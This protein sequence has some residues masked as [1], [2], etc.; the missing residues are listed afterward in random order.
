MGGERAAAEAS[1]RLAARGPDGEEYLVAW[2]LPPFFHEIPVD[3]DDEDEA[4]RRLFALVETVLPDG[5]EDERMLMY[6]LYAH[7]ID[8]LRSA[9]AVYA[10]LCVVDR[11]GR[12]STASITVHRM[13]LERDPDAGTASPVAGILAAL[14]RD[15]PGDDVR[16]T[17]LPCGEAVVRIGE[18]RF[19]LP[20]P[21]APSGVAEV[22]ERGRIQVFVPLPG[23]AELLVFELGTTCMDDW[24]FHSGHFAGTLRSLGWGTAEDAAREAALSQAALVPGTAPD[25]AVVRELYAHSSRVLDALDA[26]GRTRGEDLV[27]AAVCP[28]CRSGGRRTACAA[29]HRWQV[30]AEDPEVVGATLA[31]LG[32]RLAEW[33]RRPAGAAGSGPGPVSGLVSGYRVDAAPAPGGGAVTIE[34]LAPCARRPGAIREAVVV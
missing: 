7:L 21:F 33:G 2:R 8:E 25:P 23:D 19:V 10:G 12:A 26:H 28:D 22:R 30:A 5:G 1:D 14:R 20:E 29:V 31:G 17:G 4:A 15:S 3:V 27:V 11:D 9:G 6:V 34:V 32:E 16:V 24:D 18:V 13:P